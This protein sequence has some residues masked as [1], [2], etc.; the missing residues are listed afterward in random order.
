LIVRVGAD[1]VSF[2]AKVFDAPPAVAVSVTVCAVL[3]EDTVA[4]KDA[5][6]APEAT[7]T[8]PGTAT[9]PLLLER[10]TLT[11]PDGPAA[12]RVVVQVM[13]PG[14]FIVE[15]LQVNELS[16]GVDDEGFNC[17]AKVFDT[18][19]AFAV[20]VAVCGEVTVEAVAVNPALV[21][22]A[23]TVTAAGR[24]TALL[25]LARLTLIP[26]LGAAELSVTVQ[27]SVPA[28]VIDELLHVRLLSDGAGVDV[29]GFNW[30]A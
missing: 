10:L 9:V 20:S 13:L 17:S 28:P 5:L 18:P 21:A 15:V 7:V 23:G 12:V 19:L 11:P 26:P 27:A 2:S 24:L 16:A 1:G 30:M 25:L 29:D 3:N 4:A 6:V 8:K 14:P 22:L